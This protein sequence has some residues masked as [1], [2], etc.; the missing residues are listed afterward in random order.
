MLLVSLLI[1]II[2]LISGF[3]SIQYANVAKEHVD[4]QKSYGQDQ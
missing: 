3:N 4:E 1:K 2:A